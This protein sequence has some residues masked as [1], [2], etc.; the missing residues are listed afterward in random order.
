MVCSPLSKITN[1]WKDL[2]H[3]YWEW[4]ETVIFHETACVNSIKS[5]P[6]LHYLWYQMWSVVVVVV[7]LH[8]L[9]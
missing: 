4:D 9:S 2:T 5:K 3:K 7:A 1:F 8:L 6:F